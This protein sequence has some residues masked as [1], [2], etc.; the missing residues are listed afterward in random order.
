VM[1]EASAASLAGDLVGR[2]IMVP[3]SASIHT[4]S[5]SATP[6]M[7]ITVTSQPSRGARSPMIPH[8]SDTQIEDTA[9]SIPDLHNLSVP[10]RNLEIPIDETGGA[11][12][13][14][15]IDPMGLLQP[16]LAFFRSPIRLSPHIHF[17]TIRIAELNPLTLATIGM[18][19]MHNVYREDWITFVNVSRIAPHPSPEP[20]FSRLD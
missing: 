17:D 11:S 10:L 15:T 8:G 2:P 9:S 6:R 19:S 14:N 4:P 5:T 18:P 1:E 12:T 7:R 13:V 3:P 20:F 16:P